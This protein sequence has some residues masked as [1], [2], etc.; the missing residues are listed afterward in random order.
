MPAS[1]TLELTTAAGVDLNDFVHIEV[2]SVQGAQSYQNN[3]NVKRA[4]T[5]NGIEANPNAVYRV[6]VTPNNYRTVQRFVMLADRQAAT[7]AL[8]CPVQP[9]RVIGIRPPAFTALPP[10][11]QSL[12]AGAHIPRFLDPTGG[13]LPGAALYDKLGATPRLQAC[14]LNLAAKSAATRLLDG[15]TCLE[16]YTGLVRIEQD[17]F[18]AT[19]TAALFEE[20]HSSPLFHTVDDTLHEPVPGF[21][22]VG[23]FKTLDRHGNLQLTFQRNSAGE[24]IADVDID[25]AQGIGHLFEVL[26]DAIT[27]PTDPYDVHEVLVASMPALDPGYSFTFAQAA[28]VNA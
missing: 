9:S 4:A 22:L 28:V 16:H 17:R 23:S 24:Y 12:L 14:L 8:K 15:K 11:L 1:I 27:G 3:V 2:R 25:L 21:Q 5:I 26:Q 19:T 20:A 6:Q 13:F 7:V 18:F 10:T